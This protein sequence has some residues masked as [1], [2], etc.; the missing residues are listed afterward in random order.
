MVRLSFLISTL[1]NA[2]GLAIAASGN[3]GAG[4]LCHPDATELG[5][6]GG[7]GGGPRTGWGAV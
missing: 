7:P 6:R 4:R 5:D 3:L 2:V 1:Y